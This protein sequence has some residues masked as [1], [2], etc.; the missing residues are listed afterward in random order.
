MSKNA[1]N[2]AD[3]SLCRPQAS[4]IEPLEPRTLLSVS[5][6][7]QHRADPSAVQGNIEQ[8]AT[9]LQTI[10]RRGA[11]AKKPAFAN[12]RAATLSAA[13]STK[14]IGLPEFD[15]DNFDSPVAN[16]WFPLVAGTEYVYEAEEEEGLLTTRIIVT[17][18]T[19]QVM[20]I[21][22]MVVREIEEIY[23]EEL[24]QTF[25]LE[26]TFDW[27]AMDN[28]GNVW[29]FGEETTSFEYD[30][31]WN[32]EGT[33]NEGAWEAGV[34]GALPGILILGDPVVGASY[35]QEFFEGEAEDMAKVLRLNAKVSIDFGDFEDVMVTKEWNPLSPGSV[36]HKYYAPGVGLVYIKELSGGKTVIVELVEIN[37]P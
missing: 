24:D 30:D 37:G 21:T 18:D 25:I 6:G 8:N 15:A 1:N 32:L 26:D 17:G 14:K 28:E 29:Y 9:L 22:A 16:P 31:E 11:S 10:G 34:D 27:F 4:V 33:N 23:I 12:P 36:E 7:V 13:F 20:G 35:Q 5:W 2:T 19:K 3:R